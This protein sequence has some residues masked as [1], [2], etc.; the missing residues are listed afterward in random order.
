[1]YKEFDI[2]NSY[3]LET[4]MHGTEKFAFRATDLYKIGEDL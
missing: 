2:V 3:T 1:M 4:S